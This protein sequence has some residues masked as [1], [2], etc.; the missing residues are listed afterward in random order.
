ADR[1][2]PEGDVDSLAGAIAQIWCATLGPRAEAGPARIEGGSSMSSGR[3]G[4][5]IAAADLHRA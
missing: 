2:A 4:R 1:P 3:P 5:Q